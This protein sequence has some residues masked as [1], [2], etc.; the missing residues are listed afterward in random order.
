[1]YQKRSAWVL[2]G[3]APNRG[4][5]TS[6]RDIVLAVQTE[7]PLVKQ[8][9]SDQL[10]AVRGDGAQA[11]R[12]NRLTGDVAP[13]RL[14]PSTATSIAHGYA[15][16][17]RAS[18]PGARDELA[19]IDEAIVLRRARAARA[20]QGALLRG[21]VRLDRR[22]ALR[23]D[24]RARPLH[25]RPAAAAA[26]AAGRPRA[27]RRRSRATPTTSA[28]ALIAEESGVIVT[29]AVRPAARRAAQRRGRRRV[30][31]LRQRAHP[32][33][34]RAAAAAGAARA[35]MDRAAEDAHEL[36]SDADVSRRASTAF[37]RHAAGRGRLFERGRRADGGAGA[38]TA[39]RDGRHRRL[40]GVA[41]AAAPDRRGD[42]RG[43]AADRSPGAGDR[44]PRPAA[45]HDSARDAGAWRCAGQL[46]RGA[47]AVRD[48]GESAPHWAAYVAGVVL[49]LARERGMPLTI[50]RAN[51]RRLAGARGQGRELV[52]R[53]RDGQHARGRRRRSGS[54][55]SRAIWRSCAR[56]REN[57]V[58]GAPC[59]VMDQMTCVFGEPRRAAGAP[60]S[61][62]GA[63]G[64]RAGPGRRRVLGLDS[65]ERHAV[66]GSDYG[67]VRTGAFMGLRILAEH[68]G[69]AGR[70]SGQHRAA[71]SSSGSWLHHLPEEIAGDD[72]LARYGGTADTVTTVERGR[73]YRVRAPAAH[74]VY[75]RQ[76]ARAL[77]RAAAGDAAD[78][79]STRPARRADVRIARQLRPLRPRLARHRSPGG[80]GAG[81]RPGGRSV[82]RADHRRRQRRH[83]GGDRPAAMRPPAIARVADA[84]ERA[85]RIP[86]ARVCGVVAG[87]GG[88]RQR[89]RS[90]CER[91]QTPD[92]GTPSQKLIAAD[93]W[94]WSACRRAC[95]GAESRESGGRR[96]RQDAQAGVRDQQLG[97][98]LD[99]CAARR[100][101]GRRRSW[102]TSKPSSG[103]RADGTAAEQQRIVDDLLTK[104][105]DGDRH[106]PR[107]SA[108]PDRDDRRGG[109]ARPGVH[110]GQRRAA[111]GAGLLHRHRQRGGRA[112]GRSADSRGHPRRRLDHAVRRQARRPNAQERDAGHQGGARRD[113]RSASSTC[114]PTTSTTCG[115]RRTP[116]TRWCDIRTSRRSS[117]CGATTAPPSSTPCARPARSA[118]CESSRSTRPTRRWPA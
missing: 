33:A 18:F 59:G 2:T 46:R 116:P 6:L 11:Q 71:A 42:V 34:D 19:A 25:R 118:A 95:R 90:R 43:G 39:R 63:A 110:A 24:G 29:D 32:R 64:V 115:P 26:T 10:W 55:S 75:E 44:Q 9:L 47:P 50:G 61:A 23:A 8:H 15:I 107:R 70:L 101:E 51:R 58:A 92:A 21:S 69:G 106:L 3:V 68:A 53:H 85:D 45:V 5:A 56:R 99:D 91:S 93:C 7:I 35:R 113:R 87:R 79:A 66:G 97:R 109:E 12:Y 52:G 60:L 38:G 82:W 31:G 65:G 37:V 102:R 112:P 94:S 27:C 108:E 77:P 98:L 73:R 88:V 40:L 14:R 76:R 83:G 4:P 96:R 89:D 100:G 103:S 16:D 81:R 30:G 117:G 114:A 48:G 72:F 86:A 13:L 62:R 41:G 67:A 78:E 57:L 74:P 104:G 111:V 1:M 20:G 84:Y 36:R 80:A 22:A 49:V 28:R 17:R 54:R 105:V